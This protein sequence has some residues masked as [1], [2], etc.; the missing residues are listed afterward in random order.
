MAGP[1]LELACLAISLYGE[2]WNHFS[3]TRCR[4]ITP[5]RNRKRSWPLGSPFMN[6][7]SMSQI[8]R[9]RRLKER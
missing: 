4:K 3:S 6:I 2:C 1:L 7:A 8:D 5:S 9:K